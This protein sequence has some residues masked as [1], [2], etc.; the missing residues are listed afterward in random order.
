MSRRLAHAAV[1]FPLGSHPVPSPLN[2][3]A[4]DAVLRAL[5][6]KYGAL[7]RSIVARVGGRTLQDSRDDVA[8]AVALSLW[9]QVSREQ[10]ITY[11]SSYIYRAAIRETVRAVSK[12][13]DRVRTHGS[14]DA[15]EMPPVISL[16]PDP[17]AAASAAEVGRDIRTAIAGLPADR[18][19]AV[20]AHLSGYSVE[21]IM[22][23]YGWSYQ[24]ARNLVSRGMADLRAALIKE[25]YGG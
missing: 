19:R 18:Q 2:P 16:A 8:Q 13:L 25:G 10:N 9:Q 6:E 12:E 22:Q 24:K 5:L 17:E 15:E 21:Q 14:I 4:P 23:A 3:D 1:E 11:P 7:I 20:R